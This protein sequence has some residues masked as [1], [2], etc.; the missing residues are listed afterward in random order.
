MPSRRFYEGQI[1]RY[2]Q[3]LE[4]LARYPEK[5]PYPDGTVV[6]FTKTLSNGSYDY[7]AIRKRGRWYTTGT[8]DPRGGRTWG[9]FVEWLADR[10]TDLVIMAPVDGPTQ[11]QVVIQNSP[12]VMI[13]RLIELARTEP[14]RLAAA[15]DAEAPWTATNNADTAEIPKVRPGWYDERTGLISGPIE[16]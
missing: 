5:D 1:E 6:T 7:A 16:P 13:R 2:Q 11:A 15:M 8:G 4:R 10:A 12:E 3:L 9:Q 14:D